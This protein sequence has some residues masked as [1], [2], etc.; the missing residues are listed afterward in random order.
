MNENSLSNVNHQFSVPTFVGFGGVRES[1]QFGV[2]GRLMW[3]KWSD[4]LRP[5][6]PA[7]FGSSHIVVFLN[8]C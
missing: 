7:A 4:L 5:L 3:S 6:Q 8:G 1:V 2:M